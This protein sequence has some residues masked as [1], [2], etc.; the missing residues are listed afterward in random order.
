MV[1]ITVAAILLIIAGVAAFQDQHTLITFIS[2]LERG[3]EFA[4]IG[5]LGLTILF[6]RYYE[7]D[8]ERPVMLIALGLIV[9]SSIAV[10]NSHIL[11]SWLGSYFTVWAEIRTDSFLIALGFWVAAVWKPLAVRVRPSLLEPAVYG[12]MVPAMN[13]QLRQLNGRLSEMLR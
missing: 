5:T 4:V 13:F 9:Y 2:S 7:I 11:N 10:A 3:L 6:T 8:V 1:L 12:Q